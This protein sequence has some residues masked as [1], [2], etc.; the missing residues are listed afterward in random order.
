MR[1][2]YSVRVRHRDCPGLRVGLGKFATRTMAHDAIKKYYETGERS[3][4][5]N[6]PAFNNVFEHYD[7][8]G[9]VDGYCFVFKGKRSVKIFKQLH[10]AAWARRRLRDTLT[11]KQA[12]RE[13]KWGN[14]PTMY[15]HKHL[16]IDFVERSQL[17]DFDSKP[18]TRRHSTRSRKCTEKLQKNDDGANV[19]GS[20]RP[21][22]LADNDDDLAVYCI[23]T[24]PVRRGTRTQ[25][26]RSLVATNAGLS[27]VR[28]LSDVTRDCEDVTR[29]CEDVTRDCEDVTRDCDDVTCGDYDECVLIYS[30]EK[31]L[32]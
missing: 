29:Y 6:R 9:N 18:D 12:R 5:C 10:Q 15:P 22:L 7:K 16:P 20:L 11:Q 17:T 13:G 25:R 27:A 30:S 26:R 21:N 14:R 2:G 8:K 28:E 23:P 4:S 19:A 32:F 1:G 24:V 3:V 31:P